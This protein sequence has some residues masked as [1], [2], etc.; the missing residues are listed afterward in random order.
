[1]AHATFLHGDITADGEHRAGYN[2]VW[3]LRHTSSTRS[4]FVPAVARLNLDPIFNGDDM[5][6][7]QVFFEP[8]HAPMTLQAALR[9]RGRAAPAADADLSRRKLDAL[10]AR[11]ATLPRHALPLHAAPARLPARLDGPLL[12]QLHQWAGR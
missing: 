9:H 10:P 11:R 3:S 12:G 1:M 2:G 8:R 4:L 5:P 6:D 7:S